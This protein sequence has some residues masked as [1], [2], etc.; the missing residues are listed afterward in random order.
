ML[1]M[2]IV[3]KDLIRLSN[4]HVKPASEVLSR[5]FQTDP[6]L[7]Y[8]FPDKFE[9]ERGAPCFFRVNL[10]YSI[11]YGETYATSPNLEGVAIW[12]PSDN[13]HM[14]F[15]KTLRSVPLPT[16]FGLIRGG[17][18]H[19][20]KYF[21]EHVDLMHKRLA[22]FKHWFLQIIG[23]APQFQGKGYASKLLRPMLARIDNEG[24]ACY[25]ET[26]NRNNVSLY[27]H[28]GFRVVE[29]ST[30]PGTNFNVWAMLRK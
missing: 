17:V 4:S 22:P 25:V 27:E 21:L 12:L 16:R 13:Y 6:I 20:L 7:Q 18:S 26:M 24:L 14:T 3:L 10:S 11:R 9:R 28:F 23:V 8:A 5:A 30:I 15:W 19:R 2:S 1:H 29:R